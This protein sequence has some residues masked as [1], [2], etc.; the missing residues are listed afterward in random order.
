MY[1]SNLYTRVRRF[2][3][4]R[5]SSCH[6]IRKLTS[7]PTRQSFANI[8]TN[9]NTHTLNTQAPWTFDP[10]YNRWL[11]CALVFIS[12]RS[13]VI[14]TTT[15]KNCTR[16]VIDVYHA[17]TP[18]HTNTYFRS[19]LSEIS[20]PSFTSPPYPHSP[21]VCP[22]TRAPCARARTVGKQ[23][24]QFKRFASVAFVFA[25]SAHGLHKACTA[26]LRRHDAWGGGGLFNIISVRMSKK[27]SH[28]W[29]GIFSKLACKCC[30]I[31]NL[32]SV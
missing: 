28:S 12:F 19:Y 3:T 1:P 2:A 9:T 17:H 11:D 13:R 27:K 31:S 32:Y 30:R 15:T 4:F 23:I 22:F 26:S 14:C 18:T 20:P 24:R 8:R 21:T 5:P 10:M 16:D 7:V 6:F 25:T 29:G